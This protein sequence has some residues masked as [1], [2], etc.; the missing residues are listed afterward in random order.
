MLT[1]PPPPT[2]DTLEDNTNCSFVIVTFGSANYSHIIQRQ[3]CPEFLH[4]SSDLLTESLLP[5]LSCFL[6][7]LLLILPYLRII[8]LFL[9]FQ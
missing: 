7:N 1:P 8:S 3:T 2:P 6:Y 4:P 9:A 5:A